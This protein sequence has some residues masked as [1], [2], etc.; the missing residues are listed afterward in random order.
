MV[1]PQ[2]LGFLRFA[3]YALRK[4]CPVPIIVETHELAKVYGNGG[5]VRALD[6]VTLAVPEGQFLA[7]MGPSGSGKTTLLN[8]LGAMDQPSKGEVSVAGVSLAEVRDMDRFRAR[9][10]GFVFQVHN[11]IPTLTAW[12]NVEAAMRA[13]PWRRRM[14][15]ERARALLAQV[16]LAHRAGHLPGQLSGG[17]RQRVALA[18]ALANEPH[19]LLADEPTGNLDTASGQGLIAALRQLNQERCL[20]VILV[21]HDP[22]IARAADRIVVLRDGQIVQDHL[23]TSPYLE[24]LRL[25][26]RS[27]LGRALLAGTVPEEV[28][29]LGLGLGL[30]VLQQVLA[31][32]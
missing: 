9:T 15:K 16:G 21:T 3:Q 32:V 12:E 27:P 5:G 14:R 19:L 26:K 6:G 28:Q 4:E 11:L 18:R 17:E 20:T 10:I 8:L 31:R 25:F 22:A 30:P 23:V 7:V 1:N 29:G 24:D 2:M 13:G